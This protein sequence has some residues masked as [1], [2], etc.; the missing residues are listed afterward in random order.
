MKDGYQL[1]CAQ[2]TVCCDVSEHVTTS[3][4]IFDYPFEHVSNTTHATRDGV[5]CVGEGF[6]APD[7]RCLAEVEGIDDLLLVGVHRQ[8]HPL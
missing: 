5:R 4:P 7:L 2:V 6:Q 3:A 1:V 8:V